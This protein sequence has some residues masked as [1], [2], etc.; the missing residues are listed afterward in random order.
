MIRKVITIISLVIVCFIVYGYTYMACRNN[1]S[2]GASVWLSNIG[3]YLN[4]CPYGEFIVANESD[5]L[6]MW[7]FQVSFCPVQ[8][9]LMIFGL[10]IIF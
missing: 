6:R 5:R 8:W 2:Y 7:I 1:G 3:M 9:Y 10:M 4:Y